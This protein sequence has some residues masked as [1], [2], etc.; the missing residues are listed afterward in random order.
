MRKRLPI[1]RQRPLAAVTRLSAACAVGSAIAIVGC[2]GGPAL[3]QLPTVASL[4]ELPKVTVPTLTIEPSMIEA[5]SAEVYSRIARG[6]NA[7]WFGPRGR[8]TGSHIFQ[9]DAAPSMNG[10][11][12]EIVI[13][14]RAIDQPKPWGYKAFRVQLAETAGL[15]GQ[16]GGG[17]TRITVD[18]LRMPDAEVPLMRAEVFQWATGT[19]GC[20]NPPGTAPP[21]VAVAP[22]VVPANAATKATP[23]RTKASEPKAVAQPAAS[24][25][26]RGKPA[27]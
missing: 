21:A 22:P 20:K 4:G 9:A 8:L 14:E 15:D 24:A 23:R 27:E 2:A 17:G 12:V 3:P 5:S 25:A 10:G 16:P 18:N 13:H 7:C 19:E 11:A 6:A 26:P 1:L